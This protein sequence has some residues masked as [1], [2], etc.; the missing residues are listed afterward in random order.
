VSFSARDNVAGNPVSYRVAV[1]S[2]GIELTH[3]GGAST[4]GRVSI[5]LRIRPPART[6]GVRLEIDLSDPLG[7][8]RRFARSLALRR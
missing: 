4:S 5:A 8:G 3:K 6:R 7:N 2:A 1:T